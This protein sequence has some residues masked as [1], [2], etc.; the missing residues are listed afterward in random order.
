MHDS[1]STGRESTR[2][3]ETKTL[4]LYLWQRISLHRLLEEA[5]EKQ[6]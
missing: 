4:Q 5:F 3:N 6:F 1:E 2:S